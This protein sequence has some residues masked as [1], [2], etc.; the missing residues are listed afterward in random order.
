MNRRNLLK[1]FVGGMAVIVG[2]KVLADESKP[3]I[4][5][6]KAKFK[7]VEPKVLDVPEGDSVLVHDGKGI[8][9]EPQYRREF[10]YAYADGAWRWVEYD[11]T[12][13]WIRVVSPP[14][15]HALDKSILQCLDAKSAV[16]IHQ[17]GY[18]VREVWV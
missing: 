7:K 12:G 16:Q 11:K 2:G 9:W 1:R 10:A 6:R 5:K 4:P 8:H 17:T 18:T 15:T 13:H 3:I 14:P